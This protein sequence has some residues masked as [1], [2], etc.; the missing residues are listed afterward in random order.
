MN[1]KNT[2][3]LLVI[4]LLFSLNIY[5]GGPN[6]WTTYHSDNDIK[7]EYQYTNCEYQEF[8]NQEFVI[9]QITNYTNKD[10]TVKWNNE[11]WY[12]KKCIN[13]SDKANDEAKNEIFVK[14]NDI[15]LGNCSDQNSLRIFSKFSEKIEDMPGIKKIVKLTKF[16]LKNIN[17]SYE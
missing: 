3:I 14:A 1:L 2:S 9:L 8:F 16:K 11:T 10:L 15:A 4:L 5:A 12:D 13:C 17:I 6:D 7:I